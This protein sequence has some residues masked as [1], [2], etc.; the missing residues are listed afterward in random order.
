M[1]PEPFSV[2]DP[3][4]PSPSQIPDTLADHGHDRGVDAWLAYHW[5]DPDTVRAHFAIGEM[6]GEW[7]QCAGF[8]FPATFRPNSASKLRAI[9]MPIDVDGRAVDILAIDKADATLWGVVTGAAAFVNDADVER[10]TYLNAGPLR[11][12]RNPMDW[13]SDNCDGVIPL[14]SRSYTELYERGVRFFIAETI[15]RAEE[16]AERIFEAPQRPGESDADFNR[17]ADSADKYISIDDDDLDDEII[18][19]VAQQLAAGARR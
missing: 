14:R 18:E 15:E 2:E 7:H 11:V 16:L 6:R 13:L 10:H 8:P 9:V 19:R 12:H 17:R 5:F 1:Q 4:F 3:A